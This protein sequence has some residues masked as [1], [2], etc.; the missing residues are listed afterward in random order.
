MADNETTRGPARQG[1]APA[2]AASGGAR[3]AV[4]QSWTTRCYATAVRQDLAC[5]LEE[6]DAVAQQAP[7]LLGMAGD[8]VRGVAVGRVSR[9]ARR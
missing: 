4:R 9:R 2:G 1:A 6:D 5:V 7:P 3:G 8:D